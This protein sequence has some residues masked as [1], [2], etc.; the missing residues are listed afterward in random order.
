[1]KMTSVGNNIREKAREN[2]ISVNK[3]EQTAGLK[4]GTLYNILSGRSKNPGI[5]TLQQLATVLNCSIAELSSNNSSFS[6]DMIEEEEWN[7][8]LY[9][10]CLSYLIYQASIKKI[11]LSKYKAL[12]FTDEVYKY[13][14]QAK[15]KEVDKNFCN[16]LLEKWESSLN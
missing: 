12:E 15:L 1:M 4:K 8:A 7:S 5:Y 2:G 9:I 10:Q 16:W 13:C 14:S 3:L 6:K 11:I